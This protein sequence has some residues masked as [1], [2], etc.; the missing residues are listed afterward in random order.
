LTNEIVCAEDVKGNDFKEIFYKP[1]AICDN[2]SRNI[3]RYKI[4]NISNKKYFIMLNENNLGTLEPDLYREALGKKG[5]SIPNAV[6][7]SLYK[8]NSILNGSS[9]RF[10]NMC[11]NDIERRNIKELDTI[12]NKFLIKNRVVRTYKLEY[13]NDIDES[14][15]G[16]FLQPGETKYFTSV[17]NLPYRNSHKWFS[18]IDKK[19]PN[20]ASLSLK[21]DSVFTNKRISQDRKKEIKENSYTLFDGIIYSNKVPVKLIK[22]KK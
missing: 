13:I 5:Y 4:T 18:N 16:Y 3:L 14:M 12:V 9:T 22:L 19:K 2:L 21:N 20:L 7:L 1:N 6:A 15:Q 8:N 11:G 17:T 10:E